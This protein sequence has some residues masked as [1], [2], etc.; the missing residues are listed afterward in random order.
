MSSELNIESTPQAVPVGYGYR[1]VTKVP[2][3]HG[4]VTWDILLNNMSTGLF[5]AA[6]LGE[7]TAPAGF[8]ALADVAYPVALLLLTADLVCLVLDLGDASR[9][10]HML[11][12]WK[13]SSPMSLGTWVLT[14]YS[15]PVTLL[16]LMSF[17]PAGGPALE[18]ARRFLLVAGSALALGAA[19]YKGVLFSTTA[20][21]GWRHARWLGAYLAN[22]ALVLGTAELMLLGIVLGRPAAVAPLRSALLL[23]LL[24]NLVVLSLVLVDLR[25]SLS[26][27]RAPRVLGTIGALV[28]VAGLL[29]PL[30]LLAVGT[31]A[32]AIGAV[33]MILLG[34]LVARSE[35]VQLPH[36][37]ANTAPVGTSSGY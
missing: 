5:I 29:V 23:L 27:A 30:G 20:Q 34:A 18:W 25:A 10:H 3:W 6:A 2:N 17:L 21:A 36:L 13:P 4:L 14:A 28:L 8:R 24:L 9:F 16:A 1:P 35:I 31:P 32:A 19:A 15:G 22:S 12:I 37:L 7:L 33:L 26:R 11:R